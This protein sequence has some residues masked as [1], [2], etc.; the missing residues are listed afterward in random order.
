MN[1]VFETCWSQ[2]SLSARGENSSPSIL[3][4]YSEQV[5]LTKVQMIAGKSGTDKVEYEWSV[6]DVMKA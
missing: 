4:R 2:M 5:H 6:C 1:L 3:H